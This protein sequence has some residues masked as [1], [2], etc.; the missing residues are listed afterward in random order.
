MALTNKIAAIPMTNIAVT[1]DYLPINPGG[2]PNACNS[3][4]LLNDSTDSVTISF[5]GTTDAYFLLPTSINTLPVVEMGQPNNFA[6]QWAQG[7]VVY[8]KGTADSGDVYL[9]G[10]YL[11]RSTV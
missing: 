7:Q 4:S 9:A 5:D 11:N 2:L 10:L 3:I 1:A 8:A 6:A